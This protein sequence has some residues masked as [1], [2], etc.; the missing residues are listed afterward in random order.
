[1]LIKRIIFSFCS[2]TCAIE[3]SVINDTKKAVENQGTAGTFGESCHIRYQ[4]HFW[5]CCLLIPGSLCRVASQRYLFLCPPLSDAESLFHA[6]HITGVFYFRL[7]LTDFGSFDNTELNNWFAYSRPSD[8]SAPSVGQTIKRTSTAYGGK[9]EKTPLFSEKA[10][11]SQPVHNR[12][13]GSQNLYV[14]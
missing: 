12:C 2:E 9:A 10:A 3:E 6:D 11:T 5:T 13:L 8:L 4:W 1:M 14:L 7:T